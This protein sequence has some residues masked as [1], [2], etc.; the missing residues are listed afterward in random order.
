MK[1][2]I[3]SYKLKG[4]ET[5]VIR[6]GWLSKG[7]KAV[8]ENPKVFSE[9]YGA[10]ALGVGSNMA[11]SIRY[12]L[13]AVKLIEEKSGQGAYLTDF[14]KIVYEYDPYMEE[15]FTL[16]CIHINLAKN[17]KLATSWHLFFEYCEAEE[18]TEEELEKI[19]G[20]ELQKYTGK[21]DYSRRSLSDDCRVLLQM[22]SKEKIEEND[23]EDKKICPL[24][25]LG[26]IRKNGNSYKRMQ[27]DLNRFSEEVLLYFLQYVWK[28]KD[29]FSMEE[30]YQGYHGVLRIFRLGKSAYQEYLDRLAT[31]GYIDVN[32]TAGLDMIYKKT[33]L[34][35]EQIVK[36]YYKRWRR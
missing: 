7:M 15:D 29:V 2:K 6:E 20:R 16:W 31:A 34:T 27:P 3:L 24:S 4:H 10:D 35:K 13:K 18:F 36:N 22:Y 17:K 26:M 5:F 33:E 30:L 19:L 14:G 25:V 28:E 11:K 12:W 23:P 9:L 32:R 21:N 1:E 8:E